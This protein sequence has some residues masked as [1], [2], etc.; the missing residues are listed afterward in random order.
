MRGLR[1]VGTLLVLSLALLVGCPPEEIRRT[2][3]WLT[4]G[5]RILTDGEPAPWTPSRPT[6]VLFEN[7][8]EVPR[9][10]SVSRLGV[11]LEPIVPPFELG[12]GESFRTDQLCGDVTFCCNAGTDEQTIS[13]CCDWRDIPC[14]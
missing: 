14:E 6:S 3:V 9:R 1:P 2:D 4:P 13:S 11:P 10:C 7:R 8:G 12:P 5:C